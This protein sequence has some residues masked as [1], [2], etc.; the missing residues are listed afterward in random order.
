M[1]ICFECEYLLTPYL[2]LPLSLMLYLRFILDRLNSIEGTRSGRGRGRG[3]RQPTTAGSSRE[4]MP[5]PKPKPRIDPNAQVVA[6]I[7]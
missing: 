7:Q 6:T 1:Y 5:E 2:R 3:G 4:T